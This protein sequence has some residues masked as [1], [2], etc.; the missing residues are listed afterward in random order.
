MK[1]I[2]KCLNLNT[3]SNVPKFKLKNELMPLPLCLINKT[4]Q[5]KSNIYSYGGFG[6]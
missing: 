2:L 3:K 4:G 1:K 5:P 6:P